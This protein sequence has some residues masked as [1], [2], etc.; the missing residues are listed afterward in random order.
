M[1]VGLSRVKKEMGKG[2]LEEDK[3]EEGDRNGIK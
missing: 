3:R 2:R 1:V